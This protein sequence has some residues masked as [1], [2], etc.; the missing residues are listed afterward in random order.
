MAATYEYTPLTAPLTIRLVELCQV[1]VSDPVEA[2]L[3]TTS[4]SNAPAFEALSCCWGDSSDRR[5]IICDGSTL[6][7][8]TSLFTH[9]I[10]QSDTAERSAQVQLMPSSIYSLARRV[11]VSQSLTPRSPFRQTVRALGRISAARAV[12]QIFIPH[13]RVICELVISLAYLVLSLTFC[14]SFLSF[15]L[16]IV[17][18]HSITIQQ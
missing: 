10:D 9:C 5:E 2:S 6:S 12:A 4:L 11:L 14:P 1:N 17:S 18:L 16:L 8:T 3:L 15:P 13:F 7:I